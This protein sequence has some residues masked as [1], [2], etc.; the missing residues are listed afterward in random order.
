LDVDGLVRAASTVPHLLVVDEDY[1]AYGMSGE[2]VATVAENLGPS[3]PA[4]S[5]VGLTVPLPASVVLEDAVLPSV[6]HIEQAVLRLSGR[7]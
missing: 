5:R 7:S 1:L 6:P 3:A 4:M 2:V